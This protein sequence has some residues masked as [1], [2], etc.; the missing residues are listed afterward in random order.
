MIGGDLV[1]PAVV[2]AVVSGIVTTIGFFIN[3]ST[4]LATHKEKL[5]AD[6]DLAE[7]RFSFEKELAERK[8][9]LDM[10][11][12]DRRRR[13]ELAEDLIAGFHEV[14]DIMRSVRNPLGY[15]GEGSTREKGENETPEETQ[16]LN[17]RFVIHERYNKH[18]ETVTRLMSRE[19]RA[20][21]WF[22]P[23]IVLPFQTLH[24]AINEVFIA[25]EMLADYDRVRGE[26]M[27]NPKQRSEW[28]RTVFGAGDESDKVSS[29]IDSA[30]KLIE[31][32]C[33][34]VLEDVT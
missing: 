31:T 4:T 14:A 33:R 19:Y 21:A 6:R 5:D 32:V 1:G 15:Q 3:R 7:R 34:P 30:V 28:R 13:Q 8:V 17:A 27:D 25:N 29:K 2:A 20:I 23:E 26:P 11:A 10:Q 16:R 24:Q 18:R 12:Q 22:G 9:R